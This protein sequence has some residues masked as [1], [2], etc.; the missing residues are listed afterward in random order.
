MSSELAIAETNVVALHSPMDLPNEA[1]KSGLQQRETNRQSLLQWVAHNLIEGVD[2]GIIRNKKSLWKPGAEKIC[3]MLGIQREYPNMERYQDAASEGKSLENIIIKCV[4][5]NAQGIHVSE[6]LGGRTIR[7]DA[8][9]LNKCIK[10][11]A[12][13]SFIDATLNLVGLSE[14]FTLDLEDMFPDEIQKNGNDKSKAPSNPPEKNDQGYKSPSNLEIQNQR[15]AEEL[16]RTKRKATKAPK[17]P[18]EVDP[19]PEDRLKA[20]IGSINDEEFVKQAKRMTEEI[21]DLDSLKKLWLQFRDA[22]DQGNITESEFKQ[23]DTIKDL[24]KEILK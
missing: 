3:G 12:K 24:M 14:I 13:S 8:G 16:E 18:I 23:I 6:G 2:Y 21:K 4:L 19:T 15:I 1:F 9:D 22:R 11:A 5:M 20:Y 17:I 10:M 7:Q